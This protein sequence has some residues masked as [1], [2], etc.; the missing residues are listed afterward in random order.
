MLRLKRG[1]NRT[2]GK[3]QKVKDLLLSTL[4]KQKEQKLR[5]NESEVKETEPGKY[6]VVKEPKKSQSGCLEPVVIP[7]HIAPIDYLNQVQLAIVG[8]I[9]ALAIRGTKE[10][11]IRLKANLALLNKILPDLT[12]NEVTHTISPYE[13]IQ[14]ALEGNNGDE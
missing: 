1:A 8:R 11:S 10:D 7:K 6:S 13:K 14:K 12:K 4:P 9:E 2:K 3:R 5:E